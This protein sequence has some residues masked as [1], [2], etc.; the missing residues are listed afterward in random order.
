MKKKMVDLEE[1]IGEMEK[2]KIPEPQEHNIINVEQLSA[3]IRSDILPVVATLSKIRHEDDCVAI[4]PQ[5]AQFE[6]NHC[7]EVVA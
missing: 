6:P 1:K 5:P 7:I 4:E 2:P 3:L